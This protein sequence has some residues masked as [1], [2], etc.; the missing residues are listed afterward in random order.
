MQ[1]AQIVFTQLISLFFMILIG[2]VSIKIGLL[3]EGTREVFPDYVTKLAMPAAILNSLLSV[4]R[5]LLSACSIIIAAT[6]IGLVVNWVLAGAGARLFRL[7]EDTAKSHLL[8]NMFSNTTFLGIPLLTALYPQ[9]VF[10]IP[11]YSL[12][13]NVVLYTI[14]TGLY[15]KEVQKEKR[16]A[17][18][19]L[20]RLA[21]PVTLATF[22]GIALALLGIRLP[23]L[24]VDVVAKIGGTSSTVSMIYIG[25]VLA[26]MD[27]SGVW[28]RSSILLSIPVR[29]ILLP[30]AAFLLLRAVSADELVTQV[31]TIMFALPCQ[32]SISILAKS[33]G[34]DYLYVTEY[35]LLST[36]LS[37]VTI[38]IVTTLTALL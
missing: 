24:A 33:G 5:E 10:C 25:T 2:Y 20:R 22:L 4:D 9:G 27:L 35:I 32:V 26:G 37:V 3:P 1:Q 34:T 23:A 7:P 30:L 8:S 16:S 21:N 36:L 14:G 11:I 28:K 6:L 19:L 31:L 12:T 18:V 17:S 38:P 15:T 13:C 29:M